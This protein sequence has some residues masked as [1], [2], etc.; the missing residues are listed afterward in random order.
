MTLKQAT[1]S[2]KYFEVFIG[3]DEYGTYCTFFANHDE[4]TGMEDCL[5]DGMRSRA[6]L[7]AL[8]KEMID[9]LDDI[10]DEIRKAKYY[11]SSPFATL[12]EKAEP[13]TSQ[14]PAGDSSPNRG[15]N[16]CSEPNS[17]GR[18][19]GEDAQ[20]KWMPPALAEEAEV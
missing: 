16:G 13:E 11:D 15:A 20:A 3:R 4:A 17:P 7:N 5:Q 6:E 9:E 12:A 8:L 14:S 19:A 18:G 10:R 2:G 1:V